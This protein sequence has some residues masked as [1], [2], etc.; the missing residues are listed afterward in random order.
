MGLFSRNFEKPGPGV[1]KD[2]PRKKGA[3]RFFEL[4]IREFGDLVKLNIIFCICIIPSLVVFL[5]GFVAFYPGII[6]LLA[7]LVSLL[8]AF[9]IGGAI[10]SC[11]Y[12]ITKMM[13]DDPSY[14][15]Y[16]F[17]RKF[18]ENYKQAAPVGMLC[19]AFVYTQIILWESLIPNEMID[20]ITG[21]TII[22][23][24]DVTGS[25]T[26]LLIGL[27]SLVIFGM[28]TPYIFMH[29]A[30]IDLKTFGT[31]R[32][33][34]LM[35]FAHLPRSF[36][37]ALLGGLIWVAFALYFPAS[38]IAMPVIFIF[39]I[40]TSMLLCLMWVWKPFDKIFKVE[41]TLVNR[42]NEEA[43]VEDIDKL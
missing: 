40:T 25:L 21:Q 13:R 3:A 24:N 1:K 7:L 27:L 6:F 36:M 19:T 29:F 22:V 2:E 42:V 16:E 5:F 14:V 11:V 23:Q 17:R 18:R 32:N 28:I 15:W 20:E 41:E 34:M 35:S 43:D 37:G 26:W 12:Y 30:Y 33:S 38:M 9:P 4:W 39:G 10:T 31:I 8:L